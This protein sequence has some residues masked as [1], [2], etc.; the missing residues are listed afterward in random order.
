MA[1]VAV[2]ERTARRWNGG[3]TACPHCGLGDEDA[4]HRFWQCPRWGEARKAA[5]PEVDNGAL[6]RR[7]PDGQAHIGLRPADPAFLAMSQVAQ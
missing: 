1:G 5:V 6:R 4:K 3:R 7:L 2:F